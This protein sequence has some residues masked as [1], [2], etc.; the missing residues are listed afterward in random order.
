M[1]NTNLEKLI[2]DSIARVTVEEADA[3]AKSEA[4][5]LEF[6]ALMEIATAVALA[7]IDERDKV[8]DA[9]L[10]HVKSTG[11]PNRWGV[12]E[13]IEALR[14]GWLPSH[15]IVEA[16]GL[17]PIEFALK[18]T[19]DTGT[20][21]DRPPR[22]ESVVS[23]HG[24]NGWETW[25][26]AIAKA[27]RQ[28]ADSEKWQREHEQIGREARAEKAAMAPPSTFERLESLIREIVREEINAGHLEGF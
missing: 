13:N 14:A 11:S 10:R 15:F 19:W 3:K 21:K 7:A 26:E 27:A 9:L 8:P 4:Q 18:S 5:E 16:P 17:A 24:V 23:L 20:R 22:V 12:G 25:H 6:E 2:A 28:H 1:S